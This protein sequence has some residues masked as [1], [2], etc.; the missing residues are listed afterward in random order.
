MAFP[1]ARKGISYSPIFTIKACRDYS[2]G[3]WLRDRVGWSC[4]GSVRGVHHV[5]RYGSSELVFQ[6]KFILSAEEIP[7]NW[8]PQKGNKLEK[9]VYR[10]K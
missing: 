6:K 10:F 1:C 9:M 3:P 8:P 5:F 7:L 4:R 2:V